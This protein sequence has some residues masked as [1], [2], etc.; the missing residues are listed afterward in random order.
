MTLSEQQLE[1]MHEDERRQRAVR[2]MEAESRAKRGPTS[3]ELELEDAISKMPEEIE[4]R[5]YVASIRGRLKELEKNLSACDL[6]P[7]LQH[8]T[9]IRVRFANWEHDCLLRSLDAT[10][11]LDFQDVLFQRIANGLEATCSCKR[12]T[13]TEP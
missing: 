13:R 11:I 9:G 10:P 3:L 1:A 8:L 2:R 4:S 5:L 6:V 7:M 12:G